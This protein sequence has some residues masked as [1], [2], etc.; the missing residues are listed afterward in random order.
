MRN[1]NLSFTGP[2][3]RY[4]FI[5]S[6]PCMQFLQPQHRRTPFTSFYLRCMCL[7]VFSLLSR[8]I[9]ATSLTDIDLDSRLPVFL[10]FTEKHNSH[11]NFTNFLSRQYESNPGGKLSRVENENVSHRKKPFTSIHHT[12][13]NLYFTHSRTPSLSLIWQWNIN[14]GVTR[15]WRRTS[16]PLERKYFRNVNFTPEQNSSYWI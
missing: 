12:E 7:T 8:L 11:W 2:Q 5:C 6:T 1:I 15:G 9:H 10:T 4:P 16:I 3:N 13:K 14:F